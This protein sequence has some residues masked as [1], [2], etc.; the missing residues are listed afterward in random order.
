[1]KGARVE[2]SMLLVAL[3]LWGD[4]AVVTSSLRQIKLRAPLELEA[5]SGRLRARRQRHFQKLMTNQHKG[6]SGWELIS[7]SP[8]VLLLP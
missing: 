5:W 2:G 8:E 3:G 4:G 6:R 1:M 7:S